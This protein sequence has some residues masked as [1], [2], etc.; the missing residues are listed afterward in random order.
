MVH[1]LKVYMKLIVNEL[2]NKA[3]KPI[4]TMTLAEARA[5]LSKT[6]AGAVDLAPAILRSLSWH[7]T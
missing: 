7:C 2:N 3:E 6:Q 1:L 5:V 4:Y